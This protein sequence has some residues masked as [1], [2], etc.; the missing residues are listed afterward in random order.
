M[1]DT[2]KCGVEI[3]TVTGFY[4]CELASGHAGQHRE[5]FAAWDDSVLAAPA[6][7][8]T[9]RLR[10][11]MRWKPGQPCDHP[12]CLSHISHPCDGCGRIGGLPP[13]ASETGTPRYWCMACPLTFTDAA[14]AN[15]HHDATGH[16]QSHR[17]PEERRPRAPAPTTGAEAREP[18]L[19]PMFVYRTE[20]TTFD[21]RRSP[22][23]KL[24]REKIALRA[25]ADGQG[26]LRQVTEGMFGPLGFL[27]L[28]LAMKLVEEACE[29]VNA[30]RENHMQAFGPAEGEMGDVLDVMDELRSEF[31]ADEVDRSRAEKHERN[32]GFTGYW[33]WTP[34]DAHL[35][36]VPAREP[37]DTARKEGWWR[38]QVN[39]TPPALSSVLGVLDA[40][41][42]IDRAITDMGPR[43]DVHREA[44]HR[45][46]RDWP[47]LWNAITLLRASLPEGG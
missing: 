30:L 36:A 39:Q 32:G 31:N 23:E 6:A 24:V 29:L 16:N 7:S 8:E 46:S 2:P 20:G 38:E 27:R 35:A 18:V 15:A 43:P 44:M 21:L 9:P 3:D 10:D 34:P 42:Q 25:K 28:W 22:G 19:D 14:A 45:L 4:R 17:S 40:A 26:T 13:A 47:T 5:G 37:S 11:P 12:G 41:R 33:L 1:A